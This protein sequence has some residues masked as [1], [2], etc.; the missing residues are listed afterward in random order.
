MTYKPPEHLKFLVDVN[1]PKMFSFFNQENFFHVVDIDP[2]MSDQ[3]I[4]EYALQKNLVILTKDADFYHRF[5]TSHQCPKVVFF[6][7]GNMTISGLHG[8][9]E[10]N[11]VKITLQLNEAS[12]IIVT[13]TTIKALG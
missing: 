11:W 3:K 10:N 2:Q 13:K 8:F 6:Q 1:L 5:L 4:W 9:F 7:L 12:F